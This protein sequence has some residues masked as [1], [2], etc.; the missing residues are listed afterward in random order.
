M[1]VEKVGKGLVRV[2]TE[3]QVRKHTESGFNN[4]E[5]TRVRKGRSYSTYNVGLTR[6]FRGVFRT[7]R[8]NKDKVQDTNHG[9]EGQA[10]LEDHER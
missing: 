6:P 5:R 3:V 1:T 7:H 10:T 2:R 4:T 9:R 8:G